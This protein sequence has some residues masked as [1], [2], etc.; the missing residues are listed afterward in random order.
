MHNDIDGNEIE[1][2]KFG[3]FILQNNLVPERNAR[4]YVL[5]VRRFLDQPVPEP[6]ASLEDR[7][8]GFKERLESSQTMAPWQ[9]EQAERA[10]SLYFNNY[11]K[12]TQWAIT[13]PRLQV[14]PDGL[15]DSQQALTSAQTTLRLKHYAYRTE[16]T[17]LDWITRFFAYMARVE[18]RTDGKLLVSNESI[19]NFLAFL[20]ENLHV[21]AST[22]N[23]AFN[24]ILF[25]CREVLH[26]EMGDFSHSL[27][28]RQGQHL[29]VVFSVDETKTLLDLMAGVPRLMA[30]LTYGGGLRV[31]ECCRLRV[32]DVDFS[33]HLLFVRNGKGDKDRSTLL[34]ESLQTSLR[35]HLDRVKEIYD[36]DRKANLA[37]VW[38]PDALDRKYPS[39]SKEWA[40]YWVFPSKTLALDPRSGLIRRHHIS[41]VILQTALKD[42]LARAQIP[43][44]ASVHT[45][46]HSFATHLLLNGVDIRQIQEYLGH[47]NVETTMIYT[48]VVKDLRHPVT[49]PLDLL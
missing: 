39:A 47:Q 19:H 22:Q 4:F 21:G 42:A 29:P 23:Q 45:L 15:F 24:A 16:T 28:A 2:G 13:Q 3:Q 35:Q 8:R 20:A 6:T 27:R 48:H 40:W 43:K 44:H 25:L 46:R 34:P 10:I 41:P 14:A 26:F 11:L 37:G 33:S 36:A 7:I 5:W 17:Y 18:S 30:A 32:K 12:N 31:M 9:I 38:M 1:L 49:S